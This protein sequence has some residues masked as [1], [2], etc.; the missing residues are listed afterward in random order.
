MATR[1]SGV[2]WACAM[3]SSAP[4]PSGVTKE[5][6]AIP[7]RFS[8]AIFLRGNFAIQFVAKLFV[9]RRVKLLRRGVNV[10]GNFVSPEQHYFEAQFSCQGPDA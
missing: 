10:G 6:F 7:N 5:T 9:L 4:K 8:S 2:L 3:I 1:L